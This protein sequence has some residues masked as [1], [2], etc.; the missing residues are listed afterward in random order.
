MTLDT[1]KLTLLLSAISQFSDTIKGRLDGKLDIDA[2][3]ANS[4]LL[5]GKTL[6]EIQG[7]I[8]DDI[9]AAL[10]TLEQEF[11]AFTAR[12]DNPHGVTAEQVGLGNVPNFGAATDV[13][14]VAGSATDKLLTPANLQAFWADKV[15]TSPETLDT[16]QEI[17]EALQNN[18]DVITA[19]QTLI[20]DNAAAVVALQQ[21]DEAQDL[22]IQANADALDDLLVQLTT[23]FNDAATNLE[24]PVV[25]G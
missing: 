19:L 5:E 2:I 1:Q 25:E 23:S 6:A 9:S 18:P 8:G 14:A 20:G 11:D 10:A 17:A 16:I 3:A 24:L 12:T 13:E 4:Q 22:A 21:K 15:G 7:L